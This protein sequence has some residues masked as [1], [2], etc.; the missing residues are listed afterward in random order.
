MPKKILIIDSCLYC[1]HY[2]WREGEEAI[3]YCVPINVD[4]IQ[5]EMPENCPLLKFER[6]YAEFSKPFKD[7]N[8]IGS[9]SAHK[10]IFKRF[11]T[12]GFYDCSI[13]LEDELDKCTTKKDN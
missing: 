2:G 8:I 12:Q 10:A 9:I 7:R 6:Y 4:I 3:P 1:T 11:Y 5:W 13:A